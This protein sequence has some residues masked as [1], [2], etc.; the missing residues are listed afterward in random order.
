M[1]RIGSHI[2]SATKLTCYVALSIFSFLGLL[3]YP[4]ISKK[5]LCIFSISTRASSSRL[6]TALAEKFVAAV[7]HVCI[8]IA[9]VAVQVVVA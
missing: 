5:P 2:E 6:W 7:I 9:P 8:R 3:I 1:F 4:L